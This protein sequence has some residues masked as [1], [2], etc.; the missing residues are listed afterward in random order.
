M[1]S[2]SFNLKDEFVPRLYQQRIFFNSLS[3][4]SLIIL[5]TGLGKTIIAAMIALYRL[6][7][8]PEKKVVFLA[9][10]KPLVLQ[11]EKTFTEY[12]DIDPGKLNSFTGAI[13]PK[14]REEL[15]KSSLI[16]F[17]T[18][19]TFQNDITKGLYPVESVSLIIFDE[20]H[21]AV[22]DYAYTTIARQYIASSSKPHVIG[23]TAS[24]GTTMEKIETIKSNLFI[25]HIEVRNENDADVKPYIH[26]VDFNWIK[27][28]LPRSLL[29]IR[30]DLELELKKVKKFVLEK[31]LV[32]KTR[33]EHISRKDLIDITKKVQYKLKITSN[34]YEKQNLFII[35]KIVAVGL[36]LSHALEL[37]ETQGLVALSKYFEKC[38]KD[39]HKENHSKSLTIFNELMVRQLIYVKV[40]KLLK[41]GI[42]H[43]KLKELTRILGEFSGS[44]PDSRIMVFASYRVTINS[45]VKYL[46]D[47]GFIGVSK[48]IGQSNRGNENGMSQKTQARVIEKFKD[49]EI[50]I[51]VAT[52]VAEEGLDIGECDLVVF[53]DIIPSAI[54]TIQ[55]R[56]RTGRKRAGKVIGLIAKDTRDEQYY[57]MAF[58]REKNM[59]QNLKVLKGKRPLPL[60]FFKS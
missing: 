57:Y 6:N 43:P 24:P 51:L 19:Q 49:G 16:C 18:P 10:T 5:P 35:I 48:F 40:E 1:T 52:S 39:L 26:E 33:L 15:W 46:K 41:Q 17:M 14:K 50:K 47:K 27:I 54:R 29:E 31:K 23:L 55:R 20:A 42:L 60:D 56:G 8:A 44:N 28:T 3:V 36:R 9:P 12:V 2:F 58:S 7:H 59:K 37:I 32:L 53:Y 30:S 13:L 22:G 25:D 4:N 21:R 45:I 34:D 11:H 38:K